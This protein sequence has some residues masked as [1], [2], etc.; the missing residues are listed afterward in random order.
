[1]SK[2]QHALNAAAK[3]FRVFPLAINA[4]TP[5]HASNWRKTA[6]SDPA[7]IKEMWTDPVLECEID[8]NVGIS[9]GAD[10]LVFDEDTRDGKQGDK[11]RKLLEMVYDELPT[12]FTVRS[13]SG[14]K[15]RYMATDLPVGNSSS[16]V[17]K[18]IDIKSLGGFVVG[19]GS[20]IDG[21]AYTIE[22]DVPMAPAPGWLVQLA[23]APRERVLAEGEH[24]QPVVDLDTESAISR[25]TEW[26]T[27]KAPDAGTYSVAAKVKDFG[28]S[29]ERCLELMLD[30]WP[31]AEAKG[32][33]HVAFRV[34]NAY[35]YGQNA[36]GIASAEAEFGPVEVDAKPAPKKGL[37]SIRWADIKPALDRPY[38]IDDL[39]D[40]AAMIVTYGDSNAG[41]TYVVLDQCFH[42]AAG[43]EWNGHKVQQGLVV[44]VAAEG[45]TGFFKRVEA[46]KRHY[47]VDNLPFALVPCSIDMHGAP[48]DTKKLIQLIKQEEQHFGQ[49]CVMI[50]VDTL[51]RA[52]GAG[53]EN[54]TVDMGKFVLHA[55]A[56]RAA[57]GAAVNII[58]HTGKDKAKGARGSSALRA[59][60]DTEIEIRPG[61]FENM[62]Q[63]DMPLLKPLTFELQGVKI[64]E[65][66]DGKAVTACVVQWS[67]IDEFN[68]NLTP[69][70]Q[71]MLDILDGLISEAEAEENAKND[72]WITWDMWVLSCLGAVKTQKGGAASKP[73]LYQWRRELSEN[74]KIE[75]NKQ[76]QWRIRNSQNSQNESEHSQ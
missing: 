69:G 54:T 51:A 40:S 11:S 73:Y 35:R 44:Y 48:A 47:K 34:D 76:N 20:T 39:M 15:H 19:P 7:R 64:G 50:V 60:T 24:T 29:R 22:H 66:A 23:G 38:L 37:Y 43:R 30:H 56:L 4:K 28:V 10:V 75:K 57:T 21:S 18:D 25:A 71:A 49:K 12:T 26:L 36:P 27:T 61:E 2:L 46:F 68:V 33:E 5:A 63:R 72:V 31:P 17:G 9:L 59:A 13:A 14:G 1:M 55:D 65:R 53:D 74:G 32:E 67:A 52:M 62:K 6:T 8:Y 3:G 42:I 41:K 16:K 45:G 70:A 58:H